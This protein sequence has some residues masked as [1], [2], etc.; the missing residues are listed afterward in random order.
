M[1]DDPATTGVVGRELDGHV[2]VLTMAQAPHNF[3][4]YELLEG[5]LAGLRW[6]REMPARCT[7]PGRW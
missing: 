1:T 7:R 5:L 4:G 3:L 2:A 6:A